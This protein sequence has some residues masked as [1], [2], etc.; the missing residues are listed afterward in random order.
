MY[1]IEPRDELEALLVTQM[2]ATH[3]AAIT[4]LQRLKTCK[5]IDQQNSASTCR[6]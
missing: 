1:G 2:M 5:T 6:L 4:I 3:A